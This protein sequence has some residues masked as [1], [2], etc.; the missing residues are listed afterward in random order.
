MDKLVLLPHQTE[1]I[2]QTEGFKNIAVYHD[3]GLGKTFT[4]SVMMARFG[5]KNNLIVC[6]KSK[7]P[8][9]MNHMKK[10]FDVDDHSPS[11]FD[12]TNKNDFQ[13][14]MNWTTAPEDAP[15][16]SFVKI[17]I[18]NYE[19]AWR[20]QDLL[21]IRDLCLMLD[22]SSQIQN[23]TAK[24]TRFIMKLKT[25]HVILLSGTPVGGKY[26]NLWTQCSLLG[27]DI[28][29]K[30]YDKQYV[31]WKLIDSGGFT[32]KIVDKDNPYKNIER[33]KNKMRSY[34]AVFKKTEECFYLPEQ[35]FINVNVPSSK[36]YNKFQKTGIVN[37][38][39]L[40]LVGDTSLTKLLY[41]RQLCGQY[42]ENKINALQ[43]LIESTNDR[44]I[45]FY[46]FNGELEILKEICKRLERPV[47]ECN[48]HCKDLTAYE[49]ESNSITL[50]QYK[51]AAKGLN[52]Q[53]CCRIIYFTLPLSSEDFEQS[54]K[55]IHRIGQNH[56]CYYYIMMCS[57][58]VEEQI[59]Q[60]LEERKDFT[61]ELFKEKKKET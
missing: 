55:R 2:D 56:I 12:L 29:K 50:C 48:G 30:L 59:L 60:T 4:G 8:D 45:I 17:G 46:N 7:V 41:S 49:T 35:N 1:A 32:H 22:E 18:I 14:F 53:K 11:I 61:D 28:S 42:S 15:V 21:K 10:Y 16:S 23:N 36:I 20:R 37:V 13:C 39:G 5:C 26:E 27:W 57:K 54:K 40:D 9:W 33:L 47:S 43:D 19:L 44:L 25:S 38:E 6:Q 58:T 31:N 24:Q 51:S 52:L 34:G 3:M